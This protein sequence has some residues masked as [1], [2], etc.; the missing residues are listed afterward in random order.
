MSQ[1]FICSANWKKQIKCWDFSPP[2]SPL[3]IV[4]FFQG[5]KYPSPQELFVFHLP[6]SIN[7]LNFVSSYIEVMIII[8]NFET[9]IVIFSLINSKTDE[10]V[11]QKKAQ[12]QLVILYKPITI[13][14]I[15]SRVVIF[16]G[17]CTSGYTVGYGVGF[18]LGLWLW[19][20]YDVGFPLKHKSPVNSCNFS[21]IVTKEV[22]N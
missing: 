2:G 14:T 11:P 1:C 22:R 5:Q 19:S 20:S 3:F 7:L 21:Y 10:T 9:M 4:V 17:R 16:L 13:V 12:E 15:T 8:P 18:Q 6:P